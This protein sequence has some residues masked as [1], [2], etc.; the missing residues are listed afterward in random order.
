MRKCLQWQRLGLEPI[1]PDFR[2]KVIS[3]N[4]SLVDA[5]IGMMIQYIRFQGN[6]PS[7]I[8]CVVIDVGPGGVIH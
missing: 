2:I 3:P 8:D 7:D 4:G 6:D 5:P 1:G